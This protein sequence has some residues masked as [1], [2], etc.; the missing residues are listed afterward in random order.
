MG[1]NGAKVGTIDTKEKV[2]LISNGNGGFK[3]VYK[4]V[5]AKISFD[6]GIKYGM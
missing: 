5:T 2:I 6:T 3:T 1:I 4:T